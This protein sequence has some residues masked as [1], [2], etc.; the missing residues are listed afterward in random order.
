M[1]RSMIP[2]LVRASPRMITDLNRSLAGGTNAH[3]PIA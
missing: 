1:L 3:T 2:D